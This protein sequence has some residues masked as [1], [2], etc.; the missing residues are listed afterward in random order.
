MLAKLPLFFHK[1]KLFHMAYYSELNDEA[2]IAIK[3]AIETKDK[4]S[5]AYFWK[6]ANNVHQRRRKEFHTELIVKTNLGDIYFKMHYSES[7][8]S[9]YFSSSIYLICPDTG[10]EI[11]KDIRFLKKIVDRFEN[12]KTSV[13]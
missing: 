2:I 1:Q 11:K 4:Y 5:R 6:P 9:C 10:K 3:S 12:A 13:Q 7:C 8:R